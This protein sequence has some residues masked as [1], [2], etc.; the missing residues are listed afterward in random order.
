MGKD[1]K[2]KKAKKAESDSDDDKASDDNAGAKEEG[3]EY[4]D[5]ETQEVISALKSFMEG[6]N[7]GEF[8]EE[9]RM[10]QLAKGFDHQL[11]LYIVLEVL[12][13]SG[14]DAEALQSK[15]KTVSKFLVSPQL[16]AS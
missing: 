4:S 14:M 5:T 2:E 16:K 13:G 9:A 12:F 7:T 11:R 10:H 15:A 1:K 3:L 6:G 8:F